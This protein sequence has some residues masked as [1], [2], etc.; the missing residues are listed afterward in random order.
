MKHALWLVA[1]LCLA[2]P[3]VAV[4]QYG[5]SDAKQDAKAA[6]KTKQQAAKRSRRS[7]SSYEV[8]DR[9]N[10]H[11]NAARVAFQGKNYDAA[12]ASLG[13][14]RPRSLNPLE[15]QQAHEL[16]AY[17]AAA[18]EDTASARQHFESAIAQGTMTPQK[19]AE[20]RFFI[21]RLYLGDEMWPEA[22]ENL[23]TWFEIAPNPN[24]TGYYLLALAYY[25]AGDLAAALVPAQQAVD[26]TDA[27]QESWLQLLLAL[28]LHRKEYRESVPLLETLVQRY[29][30]KSYWI[31]LSTVHG[32]LDDY[33]EALVPLQLAYSQGYL[34]EDDELRRLAQLLLF[35]GLPYRAAQ[36]LEDG[37]EQQ[38]M[39]ADS[40]A[41]ELLGNSWIAAREFDKTVEPLTQAAEIGQD[42]DLFVRLA[43]VQIQREKW[44]SAALALRR[45]IEIGNLTKPGDAK[46]LMGIAAYNSDRPK[47]ARTWFSRARAHE[48]T[49]SEADQ[50]LSHIEREQQQAG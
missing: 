16:R 33:E 6:E 39:E 9:T 45:A 47:Q 27:P 7:L 2:S 46:L 40:E 4:A 10:K 14:L 22:I 12:E 43:Q 5:S 20:T 48:E 17:I 44:A 26:L 28:R 19:R 29:P 18:Q 21:A 15:R 36:V 41:Y 24:A 11:L 30:K 1:L 32:A 31:S 38:R 25:Q 42:G 23:K 13:R 8:D 49:R 35:L 37:L 50:W 34:T 3:G